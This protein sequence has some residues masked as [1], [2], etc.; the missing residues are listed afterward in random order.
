MAKKE[1]RKTPYGIV[2]YLSD[3]AIS[4][5]EKFLKFFK[6]FLDFFAHRPKKP[7]PKDEG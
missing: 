5:W 2:G 4:L 6:I 1:R 3:P 7:K